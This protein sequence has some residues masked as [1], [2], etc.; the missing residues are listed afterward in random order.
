VSRSRRR[1]PF[2]DLRVGSV[3]ELPRRV[4]RNQ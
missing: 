3:V 1:V 2:V 4:F